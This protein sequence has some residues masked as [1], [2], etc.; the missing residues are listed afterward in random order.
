MSGLIQD[1]FL[2]N[3]LKEGACG[4]LAL[5]LIERREPGLGLD[6]FAAWGLGV[7]ASEGLALCIE[8]LGCRVARVQGWDEMVKAARDWDAD[9]VFLPPMELAREDSGAR[10]A[11]AL[12][13][14]GAGVGLVAYDWS[15]RHHAGAV[16]EQS[17]LLGFEASSCLF[18]LPGAAQTIARSAEKARAFKER[19]RLE[20]AIAS[21]PSRGPRLV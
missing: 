5:L 21:A 13:Q 18:Y 16:S 14:S 2:Q 20:G 3:A 17:A 8:S 9:C 1:S 7:E 19:S 4:P 15:A 11:W 10:R 12:A 6:G